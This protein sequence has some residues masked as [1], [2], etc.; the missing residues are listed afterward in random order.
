MNRT[1]LLILLAT[2]GLTACQEEVVDFNTLQSRDGIH[3]QVNETDPFN[4]TV[5]HNES[6]TGIKD[7]GQMKTGLRKGRWVGT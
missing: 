2:A 4:G 1:I 6:G 3:Y 5:F 7:E